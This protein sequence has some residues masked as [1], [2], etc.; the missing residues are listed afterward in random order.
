MA[1]WL[2][3]SKKILYLWKILDQTNSRLRVNLTKIVEFVELFSWF[4]LIEFCIL[5]GIS[6]WTRI[7]QNRRWW[8]LQYHKY[9][10][11]AAHHPRQIL[12]CK[13]EKTVRSQGREG[14][15]TSV[16]ELTVPQATNRLS[17][18]RKHKKCHTDL[19]PFWS[20][21]VWFMN[22]TDFQLDKHK[23]MKMQLAI[24]LQFN[25]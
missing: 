22:F 15:H 3:N 23:I 6:V 18:S 8:Q 25:E 16:V 7:L 5:C 10:C 24:T 9:D 1:V 14:K 20:S 2:I 12:E 19:V 11:T 17:K 21:F 13:L 4:R